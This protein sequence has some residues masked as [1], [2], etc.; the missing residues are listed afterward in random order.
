MKNYLRLLF[1]TI[2]L[3][4]FFS[5]DKIDDFIGDGGSDDDPVD[6][7]IPVTQVDFGF[8]GTIQVGGEGAS[9]ISAFDPSTNKL[10]I[11]NVESTEI[12]V[13]DISNLN[14]PIKLNSITCINA[15]A[16]NSV[17][18]SDGKLAVAIEAEDKQADGYIELF[19]TT[20]QK[21]ICSFKVGALPDMVT[22]TPNGAYIVCANE[23]EPN[24][25]Y[26]NDPMGSIGIIN[27]KTRE[28]SILDFTSFNGDE[29]SL[30]EKGFR[31]FGPNATLAM[32]VEPEYVAVSD[33][34][35]KAWVTLQENNGVAV[36]N[37]ETKQIESILPLGFKD[38]SA[39]GNEIDPS[40]RDDK[41]ELR[42]VPVFGMY[43]PDAIAYYSVNGMD[44]VV[45]A[46]EGDAR[47]YDGFSEEERMADLVF[48]ETAFPDAATLQ[49]DEN[50]GRLQ[51]TTTLG[52]I[53]DDGDF[54]EL[55][56]YG[57]RS[58]SIWSGMGQSVYDSGNDIAERTL[59]LTPAVFNGDD[60][61]SDDKG[62]EPEAVT[63]QKIGDRQILFVGLER[64]NQ[65]MVYDISNPSFPEFLQILETAGDVG[66][67][68][69]LAIDADDS[70][71]GKEILVVSN[72][73][74]GTV[75]FY[76][77]D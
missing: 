51:S 10:F 42:S 60:S 20:T 76:Q 57:A 33:D 13:F 14:S 29:A 49:L 31:V 16:P 34:S 38:Y 22:F 23:G 21:E 3:F 28:V 71:T 35:K 18:V 43:Q 4:T 47:D 9:E 77:N 53:D 46:N 32:D 56:N 55:Y 59:E 41:K 7:E 58:F 48:D 72:E 65:I 70:P 2:L 67:E 25:E 15:G 36:V 66:P 54:D 45:T 6:D 40:N 61:R 8:Y 68:G 44:Y 62:A 30:E 12:S 17:A 1:P 5:C 50:L 73:V 11:V 37:L 24:D 27:V 26:T 39:P 74:S 63:I 19:D 69:V 75:T 52:D 64:N